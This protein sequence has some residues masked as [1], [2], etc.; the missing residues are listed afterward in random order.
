VTFRRS[1]APIAARDVTPAPKKPIPQVELKLPG[2]RS[3][4]FDRTF[5]GA[6]DL[7]HVVA[8]NLPGA[9]L[10]NNEVLDRIAN[11][12]PELADR[13]ADLRAQAAAL[14]I[15]AADDAQDAIDYDPNEYGA[16]RAALFRAETYDPET[17]EVVDTVAQKVAERRGAAPRDTP[18]GESVPR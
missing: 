2:E 7:L 11:G 3:Q 9:V 16:E 6:C 18:T 10:L 4:S 12:I 15:P 1:P 14:L 8:A 13:I 17:G 5:D